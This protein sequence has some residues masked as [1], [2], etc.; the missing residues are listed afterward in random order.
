M[1]TKTTY[2]YMIT[3]TLLITATLLI[4]SCNKPTEPAKESISVTVEDV[5]C[6]EAWLKISDTNANPDITVIVKRDDTDILTLNLNK[7]DTVIVDENLL[8]NKSYTYRAVKQQGSNVVEASKPVTAVTL[9][10][11][12][13][14]FTWQTFEFGQHSSSALYDVAIID[15]NN[16]WAVGEIY[17]N[18]SLG[19]PDPHAYNAVH[20][21][22]AK[23]ELKRIKTNACGGVDYPPIK[24]IFVFSAND[25]LFAHIDG[26]ITK[27]NGIKFTNDCSLITQLNGSANKMWGNSNIDFYVV[28]GNGFIAHWDGSSWKK[29]E[30]GTTTNIN[31]IWGIVDPV[32]QVKK[33]FCAVSFVFDPGDKKI[34]TISGSNNVDSLNWNTG[35]RVHSVWT[36]KGNS[37]YTAG[38][39]VFE[40]KKGFW[41][42]IKDIPPYYSRFIRGTDYNNVFVS[43]D[44]GLVSHYNGTDWKTVSQYSSGLNMSIAVK[45]NIV[46][47]VGLKGSKAIIIKGLRK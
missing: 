17:M 21:D 45:E 2:K 18:D 36:K 33:I 1:T 11:T 40:N 7:A 39:G 41:K 14:N 38:G 46:M 4:Q 44:F 13:H 22:G 3:T 37:L 35:R 20:W 23:W 9:D 26:S 32:T 42:E 47:V 6:T 31:D 30:S 25:I 24:A 10:T 19:N 43:G 27:Y 16:I 15:E 28:S 29:I 5:S 34:L 8:P 12:S